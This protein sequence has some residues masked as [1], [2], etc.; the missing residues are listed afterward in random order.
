MALS[1]IY[2]L[3]SLPYLSFLLLSATTLFCSRILY[4]SSSRRAA[5][6]SPSTRGDSL[7]LEGFSCLLRNFFLSLLGESTLT[8]MVYSLIG[9]SSLIMLTGFRSLLYSYVLP[10]ADLNLTSLF[11]SGE[12]MT[13]EAIF[14]EF[15]LKCLYLASSFK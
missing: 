2:R 15:I 5:R 6:S 3:I 12:P 14:K 1:R 13:S 7:Y 8:S 9:L 4:L 11:S 10:R